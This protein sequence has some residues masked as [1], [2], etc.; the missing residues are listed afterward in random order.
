MEAKILLPLSA[1][2][3]LAEEKK[4]QLKH[5]YVDGQIFAMAGTTLIHNRI[6]GNIFS[7]LRLA[8]K[9]NSCQSYI[10]DV[11]LKV[12]EHTFYYPDVMLICPET[13][14]SPSLVDKGQ[15]YIEKPCIIVEVMSKSTARTDQ[16]EKRDAY[17]KITSLQL[18][19]L[20]DSCQV[21]AKAY[22]RQGD[23][24]QERYFQQADAPIDL[25]CVDIILSLADIYLQTGLII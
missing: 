3:Y 16:N 1:E 11:K 17:L 8:T 12:N 2:T 4:R 24:W 5:E 9:T 25:P 15:H 13:P 20:I 6:A 22:L 23:E 10:S 14:Q 7:E 18:Y 19:L 21:W